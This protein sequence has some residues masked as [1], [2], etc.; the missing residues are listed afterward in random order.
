[1][2]GRQWFNI[3]SKYFE[4]TLEHPGMSI[5]ERGRNNVGN[6]TLGKEGTQWLRKGM[7]DLSSQ[8][9]NQGFVRTCR[10]EGR[11]FILQKNKNDQGRYVSVTEYGT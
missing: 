5:I 9:L 11:V 8:P 1:M 6:L 4:F 2:G 10:E 3:E 7:A